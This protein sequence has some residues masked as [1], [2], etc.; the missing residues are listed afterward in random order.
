MQSFRYHFVKVGPWDGV[1]F[2][3]PCLSLCPVRFSE[4][5]RGRVATQDFSFR[6]ICWSVSL[7]V[8]QSQC[9]R[10][11]LPRMCLSTR[12]S[13]AEP[14]AATVLTSSL[15]PRVGA[16]ILMNF[17]IAPWL[18]AIAPGPSVQPAQAI[19][20][21]SAQGSGMAALCW[22]LVLGAAWCPACVLGSAGMWVDLS[23]L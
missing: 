5:P 10:Q 9:L 19:F 21:P 2:S 3:L 8:C 7:V 17:G 11:P 14:P 22:S 12:P 23:C 18:C 16:G 13:V 4:Q 15:A 20:C 6:C 1:I